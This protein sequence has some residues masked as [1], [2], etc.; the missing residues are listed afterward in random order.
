MARTLSVYGKAPQNTHLD[1]TVNGD[2]IASSIMHDQPCPDLSDTVLLYQY[3]TD[4]Q[5]QGW[6]K[7]KLRSD[8]DIVVGRALVTY[9]AVWIDDQGQEHWGDLTCRQPLRDPKFLVQFNGQLH[10]R[11]PQDKDLIGEWIYTLEA[12]V[13]MEYYHLMRSGPDYFYLFLDDDIAAQQ[14]WLKDQK[15][16]F[17]TW[18]DF[19]YLPIVNR[20]F[21]LTSFNADVSEM[22]K[23][24]ALKDFNSDQGG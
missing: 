5:L 19:S 11:D 12:G 3:E 13:D 21:K 7:I 4:T 20:L 10:Q 14:A 24:S 23:Q 15:L 18:N 16:F 1:V 6:H 17:N 9:R 8:T 22:L 2:R